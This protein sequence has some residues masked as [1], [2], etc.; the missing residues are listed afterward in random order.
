MAVVLVLER[1]GEE[2]KSVVQS[3]D[4]GAEECSAERWSVVI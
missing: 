4:T 2:R 1:S 3:G